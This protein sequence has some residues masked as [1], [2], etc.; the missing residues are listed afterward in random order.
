MFLGEYQHSLDA[1]GRVVLP[2]RW[3]SSLGEGCVLTVGPDRCLQGFTR[4]G[5][6]G[7]A[8][9]LSALRISEPGRRDAVRR[10]FSL[11]HA[12][13]PDPQGRILIPEPLREAARLGREVAVVGQHDHF[14]IWDR[15]AWRTRIAT[16]DV[17]DLPL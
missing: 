3:R 5:W 1:K 13:E 15:E 2:A 14:E 12:D 4:Q 17:D 9:R 10:V 8:Q 7:V 6:D 11:A 16:Q